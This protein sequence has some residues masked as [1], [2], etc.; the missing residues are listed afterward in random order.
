MIGAH[1]VLLIGV[2]LKMQSSNTYSRVR[3]LLTSMSWSDRIATPT[4]INVS[5][6]SVVTISTFT[7]D[8]SQDFTAS[9][10]LSQPDNLSPNNLHI[11]CIGRRR[12][13]PMRGAGLE[14]CGTACYAPAVRLY[15]VEPRD[16]MGWIAISPWYCEGSHPWTVRRCATRQKSKQITYE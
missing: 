9:Q 3:L 16:L 12:D 7:I 8:F 1:P 11:P 5:T 6:D 10:S 2:T 15:S 4:T 14:P 13:P